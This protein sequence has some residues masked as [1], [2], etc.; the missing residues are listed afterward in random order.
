LKKRERTLRKESGVQAKFANGRGMGWSCLGDKKA[1]TVWGLPSI[2]R[3]TKD[4]LH[5]VVPRTSGSV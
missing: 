2:G 1:I 3:S 5:K 4:E